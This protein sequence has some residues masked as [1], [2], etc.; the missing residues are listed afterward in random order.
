MQLSQPGA[1]PACGISAWAGEAVSA[2]Q[3]LCSACHDGRTRR[4]P[5]RRRRASTSAESA[6]GRAPDPSVG[7]RFTTER[8]QRR[9]VLAASSGPHLTSPDKVRRCA[10]SGSSS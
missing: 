5:P 10:A 1:S 6:E 2:L 3:R 7:L 8:R 9:G 4:D